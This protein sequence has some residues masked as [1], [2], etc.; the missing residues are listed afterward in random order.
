MELGTGI[1]DGYTVIESQVGDVVVAFN[2]RGVSAVDLAEDGFVD[3][4]QALSSV[5]QTDFPLHRRMER[6]PLHSIS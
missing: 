6:D 1:V 4:F 5:E 2:P 3:R